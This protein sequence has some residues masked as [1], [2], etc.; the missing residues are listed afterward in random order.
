MEKKPCFNCK[1]PCDVEDS[2]C[3][4]CTEVVCE[5]CSVNFNMPIGP[6]DSADHLEESF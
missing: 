2:Y 3:Y 1:A 5:D 4:G 6:H